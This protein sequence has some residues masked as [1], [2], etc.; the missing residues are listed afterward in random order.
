MFFQPEMLFLRL[1]KIFKSLAEKCTNIKT[2]SLIGSPNLSDQAFKALAQSKKLQKLRID[3]NQKI[4]DNSFKML[5]KQCPSLH[6][7]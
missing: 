2:I 6:H 1:G 7:L 3:G 5:G 4:T